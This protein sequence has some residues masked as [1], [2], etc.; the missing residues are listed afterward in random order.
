MNRFMEK[1]NIPLSLMLENAKADI[2]KNF[3]ETVNKTNLP[4][5]LMEGIIIELLSQIKE[6]KNR[7][8][9]NDIQLMNK[10]E[11]V[12]EGEKVNG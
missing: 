1:N 8:L 4:A 9:L 12:E 10:E 11:V 6:Q 2:F 5:Y 7:E 3:Q